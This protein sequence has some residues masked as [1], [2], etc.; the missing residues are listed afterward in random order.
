M[1]TYSYMKR[2][3]EDL[4]KMPI[5]FNIIINTDTLAYNNTRQCLSQDAMT[6]VTVIQASLLKRLFLECLM[7][8][9]YINYCLQ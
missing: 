1:Y 7:E 9:N 4:N 5:L 2:S 8:I 6:N 3:G